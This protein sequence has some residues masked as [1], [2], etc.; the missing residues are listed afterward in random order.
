MKKLLLA[1]IAV[2][3]IPLILAP[4]ANARLLAGSEEQVVVKVNKPKVNTR[5]LA[6]NDG[7]KPAVVKPNSY[8]I[9]YSSSWDGRDCPA[10]RTVCLWKGIFKNREHIDY[11][12]PYSGCHNLPGDWRGSVGIFQNNT[13]R[14]LSMYR[15]DKCEN[16]VMNRDYKGAFDGWFV[17][18][19]VDRMVFPAGSSYQISGGV[20]SF[21]VLVNGKCPSVMYK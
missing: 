4:A 2:I 21:C 6:D 12:I 11:Y 5:H 13:L 7:Q 10:T 18:L 8:G 17:D 14:K 1:F 3:I 16:P 19:A 9:R 15:G 20:R